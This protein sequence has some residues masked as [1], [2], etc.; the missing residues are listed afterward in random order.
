[1]AKQDPSETALNEPMRATRPE[2][3]PHVSA[4]VEVAKMP[5]PE[6]AIGYTGTPGSG[7]WS[8]TR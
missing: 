6:W 3:P 1:M 2:P 7:T 4:D 5:I 8:A